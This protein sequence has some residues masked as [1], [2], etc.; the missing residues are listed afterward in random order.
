MITIG[1]AGNIEVKVPRDSY[2]SFFNSPYPG[3]KEGT[4]VDV[5]YTD[6]ALFPLE[7]GKVVE[8]KRLPIKGDYLILIKS[9]SI[10]LKVLHVV[11]SV[12]KGETL[13]LGDP[14]G[15][16]IRSSFFCPWTDKHAHYEIRNCD[17]PYRARG[18][19][20]ITPVVLRAVKATNTWEF[21]VVECTPN[22][23]L[24]RPLKPKEKQLTLVISKGFPIEGG[25]PHYGYFGAFGNVKEL[26]IFGIRLTREALLKNGVSVFNVRDLVLPIKGVGI[27][28]NY[29]FVKLL[30]RFEEGAVIRIC[31]AGT[32]I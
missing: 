5:Y 12:S 1:K 26:D 20:Q 32:G 27:Y 31:G 25:I 24:A 6:H 13:V 15:I 14:I 23:C 8:V 21:E 2:W 22:Y 30:G 16:P 28:C 4:A 18:G 29:K 10:C 3:H 11:P 19:I 9:G 17:D 7:E